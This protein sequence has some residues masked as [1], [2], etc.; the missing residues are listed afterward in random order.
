MKMKA[1]NWFWNGEILGRLSVSKKESG[2]LVLV[3]YAA[4]KKPMNASQD[5]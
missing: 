5:V 4:P 1:K 2:Y 3:I